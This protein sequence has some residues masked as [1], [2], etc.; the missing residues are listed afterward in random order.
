LAGN[1]VLQSTPAG[2]SSSI[3]DSPWFNKQQGA[4]TRPLQTMVAALVRY[5]LRRIL[6]AGVFDRLA[7]DASVP[8]PHPTPELS[9][10]FQ[11]CLI[12]G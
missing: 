2:L 8:T 5:Q 12:N 9:N 6:T 11:V 3:N 1:G 7:E 10:R 4:A